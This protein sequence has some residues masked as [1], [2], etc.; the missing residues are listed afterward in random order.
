[1][2]RSLKYYK[3]NG[4]RTHDLSEADYAVEVREMTIE[5]FKKQYPL[6]DYP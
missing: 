1:M 4:D 2:E 5:E 3:E 6:I